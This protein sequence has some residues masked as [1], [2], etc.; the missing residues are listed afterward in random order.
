MIQ[1]IEALGSV[2]VGLFAKDPK[3]TVIGRLVIALVKAMGRA[4]RGL[5]PRTRKS[6]PVS[7][8]F[9]P[10][11]ETAAVKNLMGVQLTIVALLTG[12]L[13]SIP[14]SAL[15][16]VSSDIVDLE[17]R[18]EVRVKTDS[19]LTY[20]V[21]EAIGVSQTYHVFHAG[22]D[23]RAPK[24]ARVMPIAAG[25]VKAVVNHGGGYGRHVI[26]DHGGEVE[27]LYAH[28]SKVSVQE[29][30]VVALDTSIGEIGTT[31]WTTGPHLH[32]E[33]IEGG[34]RVNPAAYLRQNKEN[35]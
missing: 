33:V 4:V 32:L 14:V 19:S 20:P 11:F 17:R 6:N 1:K 27:S 21:P 25:T 28:L 15:G 35:E 18:I 8:L 10:V 9:R 2:E 3:N 30:E 7:K 23:I 16:V 13:S 31:G 29:G 5:L 24:G 12:M 22:V 34:R 26:V